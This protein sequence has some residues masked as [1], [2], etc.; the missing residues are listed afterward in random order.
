MQV[1]VSEVL[2]DA[3]MSVQILSSRDIAHFDYELVKSCESDQEVALRCTSELQE[4]S[5]RCLQL[6]IVEPS[7]LENFDKDH[8]D[9]F[10]Y[11]LVANCTLV[12]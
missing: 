4:V 2:G 1:A 10:E 6:R 12:H 9:H 8:D 11:L 3:S 7:Q 5:N